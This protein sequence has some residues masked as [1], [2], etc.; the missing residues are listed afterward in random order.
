MLRLTIKNLAA[1]PETR[2]IATLGPL[3]ADAFYLFV[4]EAARPPGHILHV[5]HDTSPAIFERIRRGYTV[6]AIDQQPYLQ[7]YLTV[8]FLY[9]QVE[10]GLTL[11]RRYVRMLGGDIQLEYRQSDITALT[12]CMPFR[13]AASEIVMPSKNAEPKA[14]AA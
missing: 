12:I 14:G 2:A 10:Y 3:P 7:G 8:V 9:L 6:Q 11:A 4:D 1:N 13:K 5:T